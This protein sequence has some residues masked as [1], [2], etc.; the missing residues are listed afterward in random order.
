MTSGSMRRPFA[1][2]VVQKRMPTRPQLFEW[3]ACQ[4]EAAAVHSPRGTPPSEDSELSPVVLHSYWLC[5]GGVLASCDGLW[6]LGTLQRR[7]SSPRS[8]QEVAK[9]RRSAC[10]PR[11][12]SISGHVRNGSTGRVTFSQGVA[13]FSLRC[14]VSTSVPLCQRASLAEIARMRCIDLPAE[15]PVHLA[16]AP[17][18]APAVWS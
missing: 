6:A 11:E 15:S 10:P 5:D 2:P 1:T 13:V 12:Q 17:L 14:T 16:L 4:T 9:P 3:H 18:C 8:Q 7:S